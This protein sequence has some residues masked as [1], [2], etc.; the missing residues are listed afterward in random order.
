MK[1]IICVLITGYLAMQ[2]SF[3][4]IEVRLGIIGRIELNRLAKQQ[5]DNTLKERFQPGVIPASGLYA[6]FGYGKRWFLDASVLL[7]RS[8]YSVNYKDS[9]SVFMDADVRFTQTNFN[10]NMILNPHY[11][12]ATLFIFGGVQLLNRRWGEER[13]IHAIVAQSYW[14]SFRTMAQAGMGVKF[15]IGRRSWYMQPFAGLRYTMNRRVVYDV[16]MNQ[17]FAGVIICKGFKHKKIYK[18]RYLKCPAQFNNDQF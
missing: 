16:S 17:V 15:P 2:A 8:K 4:Q 5:A 1:R 18:K 6:A 12:K 11:K 7:S 3:C 10:I 9:S 14:P 13:Y